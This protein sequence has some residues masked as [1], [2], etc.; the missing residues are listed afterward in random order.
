VVRSAADMEIPACRRRC[1][2]VPCPSALMRT[3]MQA[4]TGIIAQI[5]EALGDK[6][7]S[8]RLCRFARSV[9]AI[10]DDFSD[11]APAAA[12]HLGLGLVPAWVYRDRPFGELGR[13]IGLDGLQPIVDALARTTE[14]GL[15]V[16]RVEEPRDLSRDFCLG[17]V[18]LLQEPV[19]VLLRWRVGSTVANPGVGLDRRGATWNRI[20][21]GPQP[22]GGEWLCGFDVERGLWIET[23]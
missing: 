21:I 9:V 22:L 23:V 1:R 12:G 16:W 15:R 20:A 17:P 7:L 11:H 18:A 19:S 8:R 14:R 4:Y 3:Y 5:I 10:V 2:G 13:R 6:K